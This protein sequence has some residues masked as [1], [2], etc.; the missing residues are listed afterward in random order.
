MLTKP[1]C[2]S[3]SSTWP[4]WPR[5]SPRPTPWPTPPAWPVS[6]S[7]W[8]TDGCGWPSTTGCRR[9]PVR[10]RPSSSAHLADAT[11]TLRVGAG[12][13]MLPNHAPLVI[14]EQYATLEALHP[15]R[16]DLGPRS[17]PRHR[18]GHRPRPAAG[19]R[20]GAGHLPPGRGRAHQLP[21]RQRRPAGPPGPGARAGVPAPRS[22]CSARPRS[23][24]S[25]P[26]CSGCP[27]PSPTTSPPTSW[28]RPSSSTGA[29]SAPR[30]CW[31]S[32]TSCRRCR[33]CAPRPTRRPGGWPGPRPSAPCSSGPAGLGPVPS[34]EEAA[35]YRYTDQERAFIDVHHGHPPDRRARSRSTPAGRAAGPHRRRR[36]HALHPGPLLGGPG[37][38]PHPGGRPVAHGR[39]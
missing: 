2:P 5:G 4:R 22:G 20:H 34:P 21:G 32:P 16:I 18:P 9:W 17:G 30:S 12:G 13:V 23:A 15:G 14:A 6:S 31:T 28:T 10:P 1:W 26:A 11:T 36:D 25:W 3:P 35:A 27:S 8:A 19:G 33:C 38:V 29:R 39:R 24:P 37:P 7:G